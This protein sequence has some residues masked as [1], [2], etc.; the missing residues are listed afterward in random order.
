MTKGR[1]QNDRPITCDAT[2]LQ[3]HLQYDYANQWPYSVEYRFQV[4]IRWRS[5]KKE[6]EKAPIIMFLTL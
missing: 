5:G 6:G 3:K 2:R 1:I 4:N